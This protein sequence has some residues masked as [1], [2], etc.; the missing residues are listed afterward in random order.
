MHRRQPLSWS[1]IVLIAGLSLSIKFDVTTAFQHKTPL[2]LK[3][4]LS[5]SRIISRPPTYYYDKPRQQTTTQLQAGNL[6]DNPEISLLVTQLAVSGL[7]G[8]GTDP[9]VAAVY[10][11]NHHLDKD[12]DVSST[13]LYGAADSLSNAARVYFGL[14]LFSATQDMLG[15][16]AVGA[17]SLLDDAAPKIAVTVWTALTLGK[18]KQ[19]FFL[20]KV[21]GTR[22]GRV[23]IYD[24]LI[25]FVLLFVT[26]AVVLDEVQIDVGMGI[27]SVFAASGVGALVFSLASKDLATQLVSGLII[28][29]WDAFDVGDDIILGDGTKGTVGKIGLLET[30][31]N[32]YD[33]LVIRVPNSQITSQRVSNISRATQSQVKQVLRF[34]YEDL[35]KVPK[36]LED[37]KLEIQAS[38]PKL[39]DDGSKAFGAVL[40]QYEADHVQADVN[41]HFDI[42]PTSAEVSENKEAVLLAIARA[43][44]KNNVKF[45]IPAIYYV[46]RT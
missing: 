41:C 3:Q 43:L 13:F 30:E 31:I 11:N 16:D 35:D 15:I 4:Q 27:Q 46:N 7:V 20:Q 38:C 8:V 33:N 1:V 12:V 26:A 14:V 44:S 40:S 18:A 45:A 42:E 29:A 37:I 19:I 5:T 10:R 32:G 34:S 2:F 23:S 22:L 36:V 21:S 25:D 39:I 17:L 6:L 9:L 24:R 28:Q